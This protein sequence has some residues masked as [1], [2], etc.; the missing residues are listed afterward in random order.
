MTLAVT[1]SRENDRQ[2]LLLTAYNSQTVI[3]MR[4]LVTEP[5]FPVVAPA[6]PEGSKPVVGWFSEGGRHFL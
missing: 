1:G 5:V 2:P 4:G 3:T 6:A